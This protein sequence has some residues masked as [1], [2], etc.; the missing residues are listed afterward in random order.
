LPFAAELSQ[1][2]DKPAMTGIR[3]I[4]YVLV[5]AIFPVIAEL[6][7]RQHGKSIGF[8]LCLALSMSGS[9][10]LYGLGVCVR[11]NAL[12]AAWRKIW[13]PSARSPVSMR[14]GS[15]V[16]NNR[17]LFLLLN[18]LT[19]ASGLSAVLAFSGGLSDPDPE[20]AGLVANLVDTVSAFIFGVLVTILFDRSSFRF[21]TLRFT[22]GHSQASGRLGR[23]IYAVFQRVD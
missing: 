10:M 19:L 23:E 16:I 17:F 13:E 21:N 1:L 8:A 12:G 9:L 2:K 4:A 14:C 22:S 7:A 11:R 15:F 18:I 20:G 5:Q 3:M 6:A